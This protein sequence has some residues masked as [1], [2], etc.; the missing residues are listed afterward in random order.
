MT[1]C[2]IVFSTAE[3]QTE[4]IAHRIEERWRAQGYTVEV[5]PIEASEAPR[6]SELTAVV[7]GGSIHVGHHSP[8]LTEWVR[9][10]REALNEHPRSAFFSVSLSAASHEEKGRQAARRLLEEF[11]AETGWRPTISTTIAGA[12]RWK[13]YGFFKR[14]IMRRIVQK[15]DP[16]ADVRHDLEYTDWD[17]VD[18][19]ADEVLSNGKKQSPAR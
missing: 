14:W 9:Q 13:R 8:A 5:R 15:E 6:W 19:L 7:V 18:E 16:E 4:R 10:H 3:G 1:D 17:A 2:L 11:L 12:V